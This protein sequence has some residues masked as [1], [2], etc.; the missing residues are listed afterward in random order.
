MAGQTI[1]KST[2][3]GEKWERKV[4]ENSGFTTYSD[5]ELSAACPLRQSATKGGMVSKF[6]ATDR[7]NR[8]NFF[9]RRSG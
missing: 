4:C 7:G 5:Y 8:G 3:S 1:G 9:R 6:V 2:D